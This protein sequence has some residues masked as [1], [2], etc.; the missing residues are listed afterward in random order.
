MNKIGINDFREFK[1]LSELS[2]DAKGEMAAFVATKAKEEGTG[3]DFNLYCLELESN[4]L[5]QLTSFGDSRTYLWQGN[6]LIFPGSRGAVKTG[7]TDFY[8]IEIGGGEARKIFTIPMAVMQIKRIDEENIAFIS[9]YDHNKECLDKMSEQ[10]RN[11]E[12][13]YI[14][15]DELPYWFNGSGYINKTRKAL[16]TYNIKTQNITMVSDKWSDV[17]YF[18]VQNGKLIYICAYYKDKKPKTSELHIYDL[19]LKSDEKLIE[20]GL[21]NIS[22]AGYAFGKLIVHMTDMKKFGVGEICDFYEYDSGSLKLFHEAELGF[23]SAVGSDCRFGGGTVVKYTENGIYCIKS[24]HT[25]SILAKIDDR[26][27]EH[28]VIEGEGSVDMFDIYNDKILYIGMREQRLQEVYSDKAQLTRLNEA[29]LEGKYVSKPLKCDI[30][31]DD[32]LIEGFVMK[33]IDFDEKKK[34]PAIVNV[35]GGPRAIFGSVFFHEMQYWASEGYFVFFTNPRGSDGRGDEFA[36]LRGKYGT[37]DFD[38]LMRFTDTVLEK[39]PQIDSERVG[40]TGGSYGGF[41]TNWA[42]GNTHRFAAA[43]SQRSLTNWISLTNLADIGY[44]FDQEQVMG[45]AWENMERIWAQS[46]LKHANKAKTPTLFIHSEE[47]YRCLLSEGMQMFYA[48]RN[49]GC[50]ARMCIFKGENHELSRSGKPIHR[51]RR[52]K[53]ITGWFDKYLKGER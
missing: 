11:E 23:G 53:E 41:M 33:P 45:T 12:K 1:F 19:T 39:Y 20:G 42:I 44:G 43:A 26:G 47:D 24:V 16:Y 46:P 50:T 10:E 29:I 30:I 7:T 37:I 36:D 25:N 49:A 34:Y 15:I 48:I 32:T 5:T 21:Y 51:T 8:Q 3:Y 14:V 4:K 2:L 28:R 18:N 52:L 27:K 6:S 17:S 38:D 9:K 40:I 22:S 13:D 31:S 35:H